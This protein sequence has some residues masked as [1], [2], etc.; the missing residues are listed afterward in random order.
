[1]TTEV[2]P[3]KAVKIKAE[4]VVKL[5]VEPEMTEIKKRLKA[6]KTSLLASIGPDASREDLDELCV[7]FGFNNFFHVRRLVNLEEIQGYVNTNK[8]LGAIEKLNA[9][10]G[11]EL[12][13]EIQ[14][15]DRGP[16]S[17]NP[18]NSVTSRKLLAGEAVELDGKTY[19]LVA[20]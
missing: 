17:K 13:I 6:I 18:I 11:T 20:E 19:R 1:M 15:P 8:Y 14:K 3:E 2:K 16:R 9:V 7:K 10:V 12:G 5:K 4:K